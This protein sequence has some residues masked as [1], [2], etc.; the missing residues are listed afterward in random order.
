MNGRD[1]GIGKGRPVL[2]IHPHMFGKPTDELLG[3]DH[4]RA[5]NGERGDASEQK[6]LHA[7]LRCRVARGWA[8]VELAINLQFG[9]SALSY[10]DVMMGCVKPIESFQIMPS[11]RGSH[12]EISG[13]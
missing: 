10:Q 4:G 13:T 5:G 3:I 11:S 8:R 1:P 7:N 9:K 12:S 6:I 2:G